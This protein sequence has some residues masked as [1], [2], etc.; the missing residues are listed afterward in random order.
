VP[1]D[2]SKGKYTLVTLGCPKNLVDSERMAG[3][4]RLEGYEF[5]RDVAD[6]DFVVVNTCGFLAAARHESA[7][8]IREMLR[9]K[10]RGKLRGV[11]VSGCLAERNKEDLLR[12]F[13]QVDQVVGVFGRDEIATAAQRLF[14][15]LDEQHTLF[16]PAPTHPLPDTDRLRVTPRHLAYLKISEGCNR[17]CAFCTIPSIRGPYVSKPI[18]E[19]V[20]EAE[21]LVAE[22]VRE[23]NLVAQDTTYYGLDLAGKPQLVQLLARLD[24]IAG[25]DWIRLLYLYPMYVDDELIATIAGAQRIVP[26]L[27]MPLQHINDEVLQRMR[28]RVGRERTEKLLADLRGGIPNL[29]LRTTFITG[30]PGETAAQF[31]ELLEFVRAQR[32]ERLGAFIFS[33]EPGTPAID[34]DGQVPDRERRQRRD[35]L[36]AAQ[37]EVAFAWNQAQVGKRLDVLIDRDIP[38]TPD[39]FVGRTYADAPEID[40]GVYVTGAGLS[41]GQIVACEIVGTQDYDLLAVPADKEP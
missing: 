26:Y 11:I 2:H 33:P 27:D 4:L 18:D 22:G 24:R 5:V 31:D 8:V 7:D 20:A 12:Q 14:G 25:L 3:R 17:T 10:K 13:P 40:G 35:R 19:V 6:A 37:Q 16:R 15:E 36:L 9:L 39:A 38:D 30:F 32:F 23:L 28:R 34:L 29:V 1:S 41:P 21:Q